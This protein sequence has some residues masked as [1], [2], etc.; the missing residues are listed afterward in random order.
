MSD[1]I[2]TEVI[3][4]PVEVAVASGGSDEKCLKD[5]TNKKNEPKP[6]GE[7]KGKK[8]G[9]NADENETDGEFKLKTAKVH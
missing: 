2:K 5:Q 1:D 3:A 6:K 9:K 7:K 4:A 8:G